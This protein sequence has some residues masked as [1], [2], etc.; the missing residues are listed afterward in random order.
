M[1]LEIL[2]KLNRPRTYLLLAN[3]FLVFFL[4]LLF[5]LGVLP[6]KGLGD[7]IFFS[8]LFLAF[9]LY[10]PGWAFL[11]F[12]GTIALENINLASEN[13]GIAARPYQFIAGLT[14]LAV[15]IK[16][17]FKRLGFKLPK[18]NLHDWLFII[19]IAAGFLSAPGAENKALSFKQ[20]IIAA[21]F[22][23]LY[24]LVRV[25]I[26]NIEDLKKI[27]PFFLSS[28]IVVIFYGIWQNIRF[29]K[30]LNHFET[31]PGRPNATFTE[32]DW[33]G[34]YLVF[35]L[36]IIY[37][38]ICYIKQKSD[39]SESVILNFK[40][41]IL[42]QFS[43]S[44][45][46]I[47]KPFLYV[48]LVLNYILLILT[49][50]R[51]AW[52]GALTVTFIF[53]FI[54][55]TNLKLSFGNWQ[56][57][58]TIKIKIPIIACA[59]ASV[60]IVYFFNLTSFQLF[61]RAESAGTGLQKIT[62]SCKNS[63]QAKQ[64]Q[65]IERIEQLEQF[66]CRHINLEEI[67]MEEARGYF[68]KEIYRD[69]PNINI[70]SEIYK[71]SWTEIKKH[72]ILGIGWGNIGKV[73]G[74]DERGATLNSSNIFLEVWLGAGIIGLLALLAILVYILILNIRRFVSDNDDSKAL[75]LFA[76]LGLF[77]LIIP[78]LFNAG[79][80]LGFIWIFLAITT[81]VPA[82]NSEQGFK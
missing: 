43:I 81:I 10:R 49:V 38:L 61:N 26:Q 57:R 53:L 7:F 11:F 73:L 40:F 27:I 64:L 62:I 71:K 42:K 3:V 1:L 5:N 4:I 44:K 41:L 77:A 75:G 20:S 36:A 60:A 47:F 29:A 48:L 24:F 59:I 9:A 30:G 2:N 19:F 52:L 35:I 63:E 46:T 70:R 32:A 14:I 65:Q 74:G 31:M 23:A 82:P 45:F 16:L 39:S 12:I 58:E 22:V 34:I 18:W 56:L 67:K 76:I 33:L 21:S 51:S 68:I 50:S 54:I 78:N 25:F 15:L 72:P 13:L 17:V 37:S 69:D 79:I 66:N 8:V 55:F 6:F 80:L 28:S